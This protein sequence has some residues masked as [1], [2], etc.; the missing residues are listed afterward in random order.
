MPKF[1]RPVALSH[2]TLSASLAVFLSIAGV[3]MSAGISI[4]G[5]VLGQGA[6]CVQFRMDSGE[7]ISLDRASPQEFKRGMKLELE[8]DWMRV[9]TCMQGRAFRVV[10]HSEL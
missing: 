9:S 10:R 7:T 3:A 1:E 2:K 6:P 5:E 4:R 8:G